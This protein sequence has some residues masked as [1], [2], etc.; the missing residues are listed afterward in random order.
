M[1]ITRWPSSAVG[2]SRTSA[3]DSLVWT[4]ATARNLTSDFSAQT[5]EVFALL[6]QSLAQAGSDRTRMLSVQVLLTDIDQRDEF[7]LLWCTWL[8]NDPQAWP[9]RAC[10]EAKLAPGLLL[11]VV[12]T[13]ARHTPA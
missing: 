2:R 5:S 1:L 7:D 10:Y 3:Y 13:A 11:E 9:Q 12:V 8:G 6:E 4:V